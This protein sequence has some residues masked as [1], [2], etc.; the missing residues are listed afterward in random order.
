M[1]RLI[2]FVPL[3]LPAA[4]LITG[5]SSSG[6]TGETTFY[7]TWTKGVYAGDTIIFSRKNGKNIMRYNGSF[8][9]SLPVY[10]ET[11]FAVRNE[12]LYIAPF[13]LPPTGGTA[14]NPV[15][16]FTWITPGRKFSMQANQMWPI[17]S[18]YPAYFTFIKAL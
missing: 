2:L 6:V 18:L 11:E 15:E 5:C 3:L 7:G 13:A 10:I 1:L 12:G 8:N 4:I 17:L 9:A 14:L 16:G